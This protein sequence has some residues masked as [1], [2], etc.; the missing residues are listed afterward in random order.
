MEQS[1]VRER[2]NPIGCRQR[3]DPWA[4]RVDQRHE[5]SLLRWPDRLRGA[6]LPGPRLRRPTPSHPAPVSAVLR[7][8][9]SP[10]LPRFA[11]RN[12]DIVGI[13]P[14]VRP[15]G[16]AE[17]IGGTLAG[18]EAQ[19]GLIPGGLGPRA[20]QRQ[21]YS[22]AFVLPKGTGEL[23]NAAPVGPRRIR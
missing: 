23:R 4:G 18:R 1:G 14:R 13:A 11:A 9:R 5:A 16:K 22:H 6:L 3:P 2:R 8:R 15:D 20:C 10:K 17:V 7:W 12:A 19:I 21:S